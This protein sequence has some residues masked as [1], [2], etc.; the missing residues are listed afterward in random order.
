VSGL[1]Y[2]YIAALRFASIESRGK[3]RFYPFSQRLTA[4]EGAASS[5][6]R[7]SAVEA[8]YGYRIRIAG[9]KR[10]ELRESGE[11]RNG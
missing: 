5:R 8:P 1:R 2:R 6:S 11:A 4:D 9:I 3:A 7:Y 10:S